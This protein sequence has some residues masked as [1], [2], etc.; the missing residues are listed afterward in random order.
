M[1]VRNRST[2]TNCENTLRIKSIRKY[3]NACWYR[4]SQPLNS[5]AW[6]G[7]STP[8]VSELGNNLSAKLLSMDVAAVDIFPNGH[9]SSKITKRLVFLTELRMVS[10]SSGRM[11]LKSI[12]SQEIF[13]FAKASTAFW[14]SFKIFPKETMVTSSPC[15]FTSWRLVLVMPP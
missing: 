1:V 13:S 11:V 12:S 5:G 6:V 15:C 2:Q 7:L 3:P 8:E 4:S 14:A 10:I 9:D